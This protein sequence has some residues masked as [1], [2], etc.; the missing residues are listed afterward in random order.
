[1]NDH[2]KVRIETVPFST[3]LGEGATALFLLLLAGILLMPET[4]GHTL[5]QI[6]LLMIP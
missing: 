6:L 4:L 2:D 1:M 5:H 3:L